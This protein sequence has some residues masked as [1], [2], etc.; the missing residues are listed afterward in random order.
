[1][2]NPTPE[3]AADFFDRLKKTVLEQIAQERHV[4]F[5]YSVDTAPVGADDRAVT[6]SE[7]T[8]SLGSLAPKRHTERA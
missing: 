1:M 5:G 4:A 3:A 6:G 2:Q 8:V 7:Y